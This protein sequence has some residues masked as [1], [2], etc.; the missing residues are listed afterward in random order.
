MWKWKKKNGHGREHGHDH[1]SG[2]D[3]GGGCG[4]DRGY[5]NDKFDKAKTDPTSMGNLLKKLGFISEDQLRQGVE[6]QRDNRERL[7]GET[8][9]KLEIIDKETLEIILKQQGIL[10]SKE[11]ERRKAVIEGLDSAIR[12]TESLT[13]SLDRLETISQSVTNK[14]KS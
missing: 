3:R 10:R 5:H 7:F 2:Y 14:L 8:L 12:G 13:Q 1:D 6:Y 11:S 9:V 4:N